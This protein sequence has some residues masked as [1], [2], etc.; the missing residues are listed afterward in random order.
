MTDKLKARVDEE[1][2]IA[3]GLC[4]SDKEGGEEQGT[5]QRKR[6]KKEPKRKKE[7]EKKTL[8]ENK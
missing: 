4:Q 2:A 8:K 1:F 6:K 7:P 5:E 3:R